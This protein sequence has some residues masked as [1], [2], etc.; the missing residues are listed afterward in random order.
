MGDWMYSL[1]NSSSLVPI[2]SAVIIITVTILTILI[3]S[4][5][6]WKGFE[7]GHRRAGRQGEE[8]LANAINSTLREGDYMLNNVRIEFDGQRA[9]CDIVIVNT[10]GIFIFEAKNYSGNLYGNAEDYEWVKEKTTDAGNTYSKVVRNPIKQVKRQVYIMAKFVEYYG[11]KVW[12]DGFVVLLQNNSPIDNEIILT[13]V[14]DLDNAIHSQRK[15]RLTRKEVEN[16][17]EW[18]KS[19]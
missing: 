12:V 15:N 18:L 8:I 6:D 7:P 19:E 16:I 11:V 13:S 1:I 4:S 3:I 9:E 10:R 14:E 17:V 2:L 5:I